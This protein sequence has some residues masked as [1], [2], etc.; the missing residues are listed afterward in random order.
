M[1]VMPAPSSASVRSRSVSGES[2]TTSAMSR[3]LGSVIIAVQRF[4]GC[5]VLIKIEAIDQGAH[6]RNEVG[7]FGVIGSDFIQLDL[8]CPDVAKVTK[9]EGSPDLLAGRPGAVARLPL[10][11]DDLIGFILPI[12]PEQL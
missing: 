10:R 2:S 3:F 12:D 4:Q 9:P 6:L 8:D 5:H 7:M 1:T 11:D